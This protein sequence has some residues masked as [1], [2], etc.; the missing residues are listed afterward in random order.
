MADDSGD[1]GGQANAPNAVRR[2]IRARGFYRYR[3]GLSWSASSDASTGHVWITIWHRYG[4]RP[5]RIICPS[6]SFG[7]VT[8]E[9]VR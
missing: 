6:T 1:V 9:T 3:K 5:G 8:G 7:L 2:L 4:R